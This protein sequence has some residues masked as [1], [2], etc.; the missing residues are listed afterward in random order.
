MSGQQY[1]L[2]EDV[3]IDPLVNSWYAWPN[4]IAPVTYA[5][6]MTKTH[7]RLMTSF[8]Q[9]YDLHIAG[10]QDALLAGGGEFVACSKEQVAHVKSLLEAYERDYSQY[11]DL[12]DSVKQ[13]DALL[14]AHT[15]G[16]TMEPLY[17]RVPE[18][19]KGY[20]EL[21]MDLRHQPSYRLIEGLLYRT[22]HYREDLQ[23]VQFGVLDRVQ[24]RPFVLSTPRL[25]GTDSLRIQQPFRSELW[26]R[27]FRA[28]TEP[29][30]LA[31]IQALL[32]PSECSGGLPIGALFTEEPPSTRHEH[33]ESGVRLMFMGHAGFLVETPDC[34]VLVDPV[35]ACRTK[36]NA[37]EAFS[38][39][40]LP[41]TIDYVCITHNHSDHVN[42]E[43][44]LQL[45]HKV[46][47]VLVPKNNGG[48]LADPSLKLILQHLGFTVR[49]FDDLEEVSLDFGRIVS[50]PFLGE[51]G[52]LNIRSKCGWLLEL[53]GRR[54]YFA[55]DSANLEPRMYSHLHA[56]F[57]QLDVLAI[58][59]ECVGAPYTWL[60]GALTT[61]IIA[62]KVRESRRLDGSGFEKA[63]SMVEAMGAKRVF[64][65]ALG[66]EPW[67]RYFTGLEYTPGSEQ[68]IQSQKLIDYCVH[69]GIPAERLSGKHTL[70]L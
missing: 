13:L 26:D 57:G 11:Y 49:D 36:E 19:L 28:R 68:L 70:H 8:V 25:V 27:I 52:D 21:F 42:I 63:R 46:G 24:D 38:Y 3:Y 4:L 64:V 61:E 17:E 45:R 67:Y 59:M 50:V 56:V 54:M 66:L 62:K 31:E 58:G 14:K 29:V 12:A 48:T 10:S 16:E 44:L 20:V 55:A 37:G 5:M 69:L 6:Y 23:S 43:S 32:D 41:P 53:G 60:Y 40:D 1:F 18:L 2:R 30:S 39:S 65:Y 7:R 35:V 9:N 22:A 51:H 47:T 33:V 15:S 34:S